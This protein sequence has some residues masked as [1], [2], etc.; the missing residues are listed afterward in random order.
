MTN[1]AL[2]WTIEPQQRLIAASKDKSVAVHLVLSA[3]IDFAT[4]LFDDFATA[5]WYFLFS[6][7]FTAFAALSSSPSPPDLLELSPPPSDFL[8]LASQYAFN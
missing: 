7:A 2:T 8:F 1:V 3:S 4:T 5:A 6:F